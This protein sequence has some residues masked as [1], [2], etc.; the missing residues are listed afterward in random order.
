MK[1]DNLNPLPIFVFLALA[2]FLLPS[3]VWADESDYDLVPGERELIE[4]SFSLSTPDEVELDIYLDLPS[5]WYGSPN[6]WQVKTRSL[7]WFTRA[8]AD[9][10]LETWVVT[11][12]D[13][14]SGDYEIGVVWEGE[15]ISLDGGSTT[16]TV[17]VLLHGWLEVETDQVRLKKKSTEEV[18]VTL[19]SNGPMTGDITIE[20][21]NF[22]KIRYGDEISEGG[23]LYLERIDVRGERSLT[24]ELEP[25]ESGDGWV[26]LDFLG[27]TRA[28]YV[29]SFELKPHRIRIWPII[30]ICLIALIAAL[31]LLVV[32]ARRRA[33]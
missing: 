31:T 23:T 17:R 12:E 10:K 6:R 16:R 21:P 28:I 3:M 13:T 20:C 24:L 29:E 8:K 7:I 26:E 11:P 32:V 5:G 33:S 30:A 15:H 9:V 27:S 25:I 14:P 4:F 18:E 1:M 22:I 2:F 19:R